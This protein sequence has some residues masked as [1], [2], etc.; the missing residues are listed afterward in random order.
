MS[1]QRLTLFATLGVLIAIWVAG[2]NLGGIFAWSASDIGITPPLALIALDAYDLRVAPRTALSPAE[3]QSRR[4]LADVRHGQAATA[5]SQPP[6]R[7]TPRAV[8]HGRSSEPSIG[9]TASAAGQSAL[10]GATKNFSLAQAASIY[11]DRR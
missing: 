9:S 8:S 4:A 2:E 11:P 6:P 10:L 5:A 1:R 7:S 3:N